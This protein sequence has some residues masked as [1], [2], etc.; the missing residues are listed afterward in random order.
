MRD[1]TSRGGLVLCNGVVFSLSGSSANRRLGPPFPLQD[2]N[3]REREEAAV[4]RTMHT[5]IALT[6]K[7]IQRLRLQPWAA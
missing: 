7:K 3:G 2:E 4:S 1:C 5:V 6:S